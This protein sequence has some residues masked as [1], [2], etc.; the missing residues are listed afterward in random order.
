MYSDLEDILYEVITSN[1]GFNESITGSVP[2]GSLDIG[3]VYEVYTE[4]DQSTGTSLAGQTWAMPGAQGYTLFSSN[5]RFEIEVVAAPT[6]TSI[7]PTS[8]ATAGGT[9]VTITGTNLSSATGVTIGGVAATS[10]SANTATSITCVTP[11]GTAGTASVVVTTPGGANIANS[12][13][14]YLAAPTVTAISPASGSTAGG[15]TVILTGT[16]FT[17]AAGVT[18]GGAAATNVIVLSATSIACTAPAGAA[19]ARSVLVTT[20]G[21]SNAANSL[22]TY[23]AGTVT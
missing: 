2:P 6:V 20:G 22:F 7:A 21:G 19:G 15:T 8:G 18:I 14:T 10:L 17:G 9:S 12:L 1:P 3:L 4:F 11:A 16:N 5:T 23:A 13:F